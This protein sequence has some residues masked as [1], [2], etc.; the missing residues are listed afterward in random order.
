MTKNQKELAKKHGTPNQFEKACYR[1]FCS[2]EITWGEYARGVA[3]YVREW[4]KAGE[5]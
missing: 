5:S 4:T 1:A 2:G 3:E